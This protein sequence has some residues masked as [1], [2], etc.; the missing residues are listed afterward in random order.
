[1]N[2]LLAAIIAVFLGLPALSFGED[3]DALVSKTID[4]YGGREGLVRASVIRQTGKVVVPGGKKA[5]G[6]LTRIFQRPDKLRIEI[7][8]PME[9]MESRVLSG[10]K[11]WRQGLAVFGPAYDAMVLQAAR[12]ALPLNLLEGK[13]NLRDLGDAERDGKKLRVL[14]LP[15]GGEMTLTVEIEKETGTIVRTVGKNT[16]GPGTFAIEFVATYGDFRK[17][18]GL[19][20]AFREG[21]YAMGNHTGE[22]ILE[23]IEI[24]KGIDAETFLPTGKGGRK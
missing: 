24:L 17:V 23:K 8:Y 10:A 13:R 3:M 16:A 22:T 11:G 18:D 9:P 7:T 15:L 6:A 4:A 5:D 1:M 14:E 19:L 21:N 12:I 2:R 20:F